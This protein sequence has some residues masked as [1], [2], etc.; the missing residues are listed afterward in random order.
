MTPLLHQKHVRLR[1]ARRLALN[2][3]IDAA[4]AR[5][6]VGCLAFAA[7]SGSSIATTASIGQVALPQMKAR[8]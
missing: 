3:G 1:E 5:H 4:M 7:V 8:N 2:D 6:S